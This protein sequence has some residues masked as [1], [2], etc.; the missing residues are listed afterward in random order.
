MDEAAPLLDEARTLF[1]G[2]GAT[3]WLERLEDVSAGREPEPAVS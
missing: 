2:M 1:E 3:R